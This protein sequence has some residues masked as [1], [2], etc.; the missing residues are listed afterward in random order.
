MAAE[1]VLNQSWDQPTDLVEKDSSGNADASDDRRL[2]AEAA[3]TCEQAAAG[4]LEPRVLYTQGSGDVA[5]LCRAVNHML[6]MTDPF[7]RE[8]G[9]SL[10]YAS[11]GKFFRRVLLR[12]MRG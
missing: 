2:L 9:A 6:D 3:K 1:K 12:G 11:R 8:V 7:L 5:R 4:N 10:E